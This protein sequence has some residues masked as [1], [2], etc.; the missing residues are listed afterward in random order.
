M[1]S[2]KPGPEVKQKNTRQADKTYELRNVDDTG[3]RHQAKNGFCTV[4]GNDLFTHFRSTGSKSRLDFLEHLCAGDLTYT[5][6][7][8]ALDYMR[9]MKLP[10]KTIVLF[11]SHPHRIS[12]G[13][14]AWQAHL[15]TLGIDRIT[16]KPD[17]I[18][19]A[20]EGAL[21]GSICDAG[22]LS[23]TV[24]LSDDAGQ[25][26]VGD[27]HAL[28]WVHL[29]RLIRKQQNTNEI[30]FARVQAVL[31][32]VW[33][34]YRELS[35]FRQ[36]PCDAQREGLSARFDAIFEQRT[37]DANLDNLL[38]RLKVNKGELLR[39]LDYPSTPLHS[40]SAERDIRSQ[41][42]RRAVSQG[43]RS[44]S[45]RAARDAGLGALK[46]CQKLG[47]SFWQY[48]RARLGVAGAVCVPSLA[49]LIIQRSMARQFSPSCHNSN[50]DMRGLYE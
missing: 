37:G 36:D 2:R 16:V 50:H 19:I 34:F 48:A 11:A 4:I 28:C 21:W 42:T 39:V 12:R 13:E 25:F 1:P 10:E 29:E 45:G 41:V 40:N 22:R 27:A 35:A 17:P 44:Q 23:D 18:K 26:N 24:I 9:R 5:V 32:S 31:T 47:V 6:N 20:T 30:Q 7:D 15:A 46:T 14:D 43:T 38:R 33:N 3:A 8:E 49:D